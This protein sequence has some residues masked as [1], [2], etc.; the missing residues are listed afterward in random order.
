M[1]FLESAVGEDLKAVLPN[2]LA[3]TVPQGEI[4]SVA[5]KAV[6]S[7]RE[8]IASRM[9]VVDVHRHRSGGPTPEGLAVSRS[10][11]TP[12]SAEAK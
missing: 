12:P 4:A 5:E 6:A 7:T 2:V 11:R 10:R 8:S 3:K 9:I 1:E